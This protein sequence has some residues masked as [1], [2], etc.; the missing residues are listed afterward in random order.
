VALDFAFA[1]LVGSVVLAPT[2]WLGRLLTRA[3]LCALGRV[4]YGVY[5]FHVPVLGLARRL[6]PALALR[7]ELLF[8]LALALSWA[9]AAL[10]FRFF[11]A[12][13]LLLGRKPALRPVNASLQFQ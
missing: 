10:S 1:A 12:P 4:S 6:L 9:L 11:E 8:A 5:L 3:P 13:L 2:T 7:P